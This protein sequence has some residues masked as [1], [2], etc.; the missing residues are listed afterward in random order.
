MLTTQLYMHTHDQT[1]KGRALPLRRAH[2]ASSGSP[3]SQHDLPVLNSPS[4]HSSLPSTT[5]DRISHD[6]VSQ[7]SGSRAHRPHALHGYSLKP[8]HTLVK[9][10]CVVVLHHSLTVVF[11]TLYM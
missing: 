8:T 10:R 6:H 1:K 2:I 5:I 9:N 11:E 7:A 4:A 3:A